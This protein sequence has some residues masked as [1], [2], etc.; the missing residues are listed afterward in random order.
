MRLP[1]LL[2]KR[3]AVALISAGL[4]AGLVPQ[5]AMA[6]TSPTISGY[7][8]GAN[9]VTLTIN[10]NNFG[11]TAATVTIDG[12]PA[13]VVSWS[14]TSIEVD[15]PAAAG[16]GT[17][18]VAT[19]LGVQASA[20]FN[21]VERGYYTLTSGGAVTGHGNIQTYGDLTTLGTPVTSPAIQLVPTPDYGGYWILTQNGSVYAFGDAAN[22][23]S[24]PA[25]I[26][27]VG[28]A[29]MPSGTGAYVLSSTGTV[30][31]LGSAQNYGSPPDPI[32][33]SAIAATAS[34]AGY[35]VLSSN[36]TIYPFG[37]AA[38][39]GSAT[40]PP[41][42]TVPAA[43]YPSGTLV[44]VAQTGPIFLIE[45]G[46]LY[47]IPNV[48][49]LKGL[50]YAVAKVHVVPNLTG[51]TLG[52]PML[53][54]FPDGT[55]V[56]VQNSSTAYLVENGMLHPFASINMLNA[57]GIPQ[58]LVQN[59]PAIQPNW[60]VGST[61]TNAAPYVPNGTLYRV[62]HTTSVYILINGT[63]QQIANGSVFAGMGLK[64]SQVNQVK[65]L[66]SYPAGSPLASPAPILNDGTLWKAA[67]NGA[68]YVAESGAL[69]H[70]P[71]G[72]IF[73][74]LGFNWK[75]ITTIPSLN[76]LKTGP[77]VGST[78]IPAGSPQQAPSTTAVDLVP[79]T[80]NLGYWILWGNG[81]VT[82]VGDAVSLG[83]LSSNQL[84]ASQAVSMAVTPDQGGYTILVASGQSYSF[85]DAL[86]SIA[87]SGAVSLAMSATPAPAPAATASGFF[88]MAY[89]SFM[90]HYD[91]SYSTLVNNPAGLS[92]IIP[93]WYY[94]QQNPT[95]LAWTINGSASTATKY[96]TITQQV[97]QQA[98]S[99]GVQVWPMIGAISVGPFQN[100][101]NID[102]TVNQIVN[103]VQQN[104]YDG[105]TID[106]EPS[107]FG[108]LT[109][110]QVSQQYTNFVDQL[111]PALHAIGK[112]LMVD[113]YA[114]FFP[115]SPYN[116]PAIAPYVDYINIMTYGHYDYATQA[117]ADASLP[118]MQS[119]YQNAMAEGVKPSQIIMGF[120]AYGDYWSFNNSGLDQNAPLGN[121]GYVSASQFQ[122]LLTLNPAIQSQVVFDP[123]D[124]SAI[125]MTNEYVNAQGQ[126]TVN[127]TGQAVAPTEQLSPS[128]TYNPQV[129]NLQGLLNYIL[130][131][132]AVENNQP[133][134][135][136]LR[137]PQTGTYDPLTTQ[138]VTQFQKD[139][140]V[141]GAAPGI[142][143]AATQA[144]LKQVISQYNMGEYQY[145]IDTTQSMQNRVQQVAQADNLG[146]MAVWRIPFESSDF[147]PTLEST[148]T[149]SRPAQ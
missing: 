106:F 53:I 16:P 146:G 113:T 3:S 134:P 132:Y 34:G 109:L 9:Q 69:R 149:V 111:G 29:V 120:G 10:G 114:S 32:Q 36:G 138:A 144:A 81:Q 128:Q 39:L 23:G 94:D 14:D 35:W 79:T 131:R 43:T 133:V 107:S 51:Y 103:T 52:L 127:S 77:D 136:F 73:N 6:Q 82:T 119:V 50:G 135:S 78:A 55:A 98:H 38:N 57:I 33:A 42:P 129:Q 56:K 74:A 112:K 124:G 139:F 130:V 62:N 83:Q 41:A 125:L 91:G 68:V 67:G 13:T 5:L 65:S 61:I 99:E 89:G 117:G 87:E 115:N 100:A 84:G 142:Y 80:D 122:Q 105:I 104:N 46:V 7:S 58:S 20:T 66:P 17:I 95:T 90:P 75:A 121:D 48:A 47:H 11:T 19:A 86:P 140:N 12:T 137:L 22:F 27:A 92:A 76:G 31:S 18:D 110:A 1:M 145:W 44:K 93:T 97:V 88:S 118:W 59:V 96:P 21:G 141:T 123:A 8:A 49:I 70:I 126:W 143:D 15:L 40:L 2:R 116:L 147:W 37:D 101:N 28:M 71:T 54:P 72:K 24:A 45:N 64:W 108:G 85:G 26:T 148:V 4:L 63:L 102:L 30:Y 60:P 25:P